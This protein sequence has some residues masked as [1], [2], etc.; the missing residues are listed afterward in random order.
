MAST[1]QLYSI[2]TMPHKFQYSPVISCLS[3]APST[4]CQEIVNTLYSHVFVVYICNIG[5]FSTDSSAGKDMVAFQIV[6]H[7]ITKW[8]HKW[9]GII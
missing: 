3:F 4:N 8:A 9:Q 7:I 6:L 1:L 5:S 2:I